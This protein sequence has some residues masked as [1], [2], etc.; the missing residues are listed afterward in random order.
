MGGGY[1]EMDEGYDEVE[2][3]GGGKMENLVA[4]VDG[5]G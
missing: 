5:L 1:D 2:G 4:T 3:G